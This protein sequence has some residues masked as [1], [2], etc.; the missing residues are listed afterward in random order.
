MNRGS[1]A[2]KLTFKHVDYQNI[3]NMKINY[4]CEEIIKN[5]LDNDGEFLI[6][7]VKDIKKNHWG[8]LHMLPIQSYEKD[9][10]MW[11]W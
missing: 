8:Y 3:L 10:T 6:C 9:R 1:L 11:N 4:W 5:L 2:I 7:L